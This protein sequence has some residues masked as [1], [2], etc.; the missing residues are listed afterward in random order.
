MDEGGRGGF[1]ILSEAKE[2]SCPFA[3]EIL[4]LAPL[5]EDDE[6]LTSGQLE[7]PA[8]RW[9]FPIAA[10]GAWSRRRPSGS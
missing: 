10:R 4:R 7:S 6:A 9:L 3:D 1:V 5:A 2:I 8:E